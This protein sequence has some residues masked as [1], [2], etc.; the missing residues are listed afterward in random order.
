MQ[1]PGPYIFYI[2]ATVVGENNARG[3]LTL[4]QGKTQAS[5]ELQPMFKTD[6]CLRHERLVSLYE[7]D[8]VTFI[9]QKK[10]DV[11]L[12]FLRVGLHYMLGEQYFSN[13]N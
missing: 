3:N 5:I 7:T 8:V 13:S 10:G 4:K 11:N 2:C 12:I 9:F 6:R 1:Y